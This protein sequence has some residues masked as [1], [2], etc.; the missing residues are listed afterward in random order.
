MQKRKA[1][2]WEQRK[3]KDVFDFMQNNALSRAELSCDRG[4]VLNVHYGDILVKYGEVLDVERDELTYLLDS[5]LVNKY[6]SSLLQNGD[7][8]IADAAEDE[9]VG[10][11][12]EV[13][14]LT[15]EKVLSGLHTIPCRPRIN[16]AEGYLGYYMNSR[17]YHNQLL[18]LIQGTKISSISKS[19]IQETEIMFLKSENEQAQIGTYFRGL[20]H[21]ITLHQCK[22]KIKYIGERFAW[23]QR[24]LGEICTNMS[25]GGDI[26]KDQLVEKG[27]YPVITNALN[28]DGIVGYYDNDYRIKAPAVTVTGRGD[29]GHAKARK[30]DFTPVVRLLTL[31]TKHD[32]DFLENIINTINIVNESTGVPQLTVPQLSKYMIFI[33]PTLEEEKKIGEYLLS[34][35]NLI[36]LHQRKQKRLK[37]LLKSCEKYITTAMEK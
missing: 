37:I 29:V 12:S 27:K 34:L 19:A 24:K 35:D 30:T 26:N 17:A 25:A 1:N 4:E 8:I 7:V 18:P 33:P 31:E 11:C 16:F 28:N 32:V 14:G 36:T 13:A 22:Y 2:D 5:T 9:T 20:D 15:T 6:Q 21:L 23:E 3:F 10:K